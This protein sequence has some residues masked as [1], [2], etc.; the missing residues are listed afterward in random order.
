M[1]SLREALD[2]A[3]SSSTPAWILFVA[4]YPRAGRWGRGHAHSSTRRV[5]RDVGFA[6]AFGFAVRQWLVPWAKAQQAALEE[7]DS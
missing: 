3:L 7:T 1:Q 6:W 2:A 4:A 5:L